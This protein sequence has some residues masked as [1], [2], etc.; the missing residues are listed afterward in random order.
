M[1]TAFEIAC[2][3]FRRFYGLWIDTPPFLPRT[4]YF[5]EARL[6]EESWRELREEAL[7]V[8]RDLDRVPRFHELLADQASISANDGRDWRMFM[9]RAYRADWRHFTAWCGARGREVL[10]AAPDTLA[11]YLTELARDHH[12]STLTRRLAAIAAAHAAAGYDSPASAPGVRT[13]MA[14]IR[15]VKGTAPGTQKK[16]LLVADLERVVAAL[17]ENLL[18]ARDAALLL[19]GFAGAFRRSELVGLTVTCEDGES[20]EVRARTVDVSAT[21]ASILLDRFVRLRALIMLS[22]DRSPAKVW[23]TVRSNRSD[24]STGAPVIGVEYLGGARDPFRAGSN[25]T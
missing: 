1:P 5:P 18:G 20:F 13:L 23:A 12:V 4:E 25:F 16:P 15:R 21:G 2:R 24:Q 17:P 11:L 14:G 8:A 22:N 3:T 10:P 19:V 6:F 9:L 7:G